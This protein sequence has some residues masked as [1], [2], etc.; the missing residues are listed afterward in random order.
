MPENLTIYE[1][2][3]ITDQKD[4]ELVDRIIK[5]LPD[6]D[7]EIIRRR[8]AYKNLSTFE[9]NA[10]RRISQKV[11][12]IF[13]KHV[14]K[15]VGE[16]LVKINLDEEYL[17]YS[18]FDFSSHD[19]SDDNLKELK[20]DYKAIT[21]L[22]VKSML[23]NDNIASQLTTDEYNLIKSF[24]ANRGTISPQAREELSKQGIDEVKAKLLIT[25]VI[26]KMMG[27]LKS[28]SDTRK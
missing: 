12:D 17:L 5:T 21:L 23:E 28:L 11:K 6:G 10:Y 15:R 18:S 3:G 9:I 27:I 26:Y 24:V 8:H 13:K 1:E 7:Q 14:R 22:F 2:I 25:N 16:A 20:L 19:K 4:I